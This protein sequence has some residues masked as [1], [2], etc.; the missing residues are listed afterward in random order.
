MKP[1]N[2]RIVSWGEKGSEGRE[3]AAIE[4]IRTS[5]PLWDI[6]RGREFEV[7]IDKPT[8]LGATDADGDPCILKVVEVSHSPH[9]C[10]SC[11]GMTVSRS[12]ASPSCPSAAAAKNPQAS[13]APAPQD[14]QQPPTLA[15]RAIML[16]TQSGS[17]IAT[18]DACL[19]TYSFYAGQAAVLFRAE[20]QLE[21]GGEGRQ[22][23]KDR[24]GLLSRGKGA[25]LSL[26]R[27]RRP[28]A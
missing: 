6:A 27:V 15:G 23:R 12:L 18:P 1:A 17:Q 26:L 20:H 10:P 13:R 11:E 2:I 3:L 19:V 24:A 16:Q 21:Q 8:V 14:T 22:G 28:G 9:M 7:T 25:D 4:S 5:K